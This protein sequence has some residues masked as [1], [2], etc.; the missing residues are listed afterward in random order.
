MPYFSGKL[1]QGLGLEAVFESQSRVE[2]RVAQVKEAHDSTG[3]HI[4]LVTHMPIAE[5]GEK[6]P[7]ELRVKA[8]NGLAVLFLQRGYE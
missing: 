7:R 4:C 3:L 5:A 1:K 6:G 8:K 2:D